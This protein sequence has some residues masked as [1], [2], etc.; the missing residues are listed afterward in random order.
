MDILPTEQNSR[1]TAILLAVIALILI[2]LIGFHWLVVR[3]LDLAEQSA[4]V[5]A[6]IERF[7]RVANQRESVQAQL[8]RV[9][10]NRSDEQ[11][12]LDETEFDAAATGMAERLKSTVETLAEDQELCQVTTTQNIRPREEERFE[13]AIV[14]TRM[15]CRIEDFMRIL[16]QLESQPPAVFFDDINISFRRSVRRLRN[17]DEQQVDPTLDIRFDMISYYKAASGGGQ[18]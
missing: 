7:Q 15:R 11:F 14:K 16:Y 17:R 8:S 12:F 5:E 2:Y 18:G 10:E 9:D 6:Q 4:E 3:H 1:V 13:R